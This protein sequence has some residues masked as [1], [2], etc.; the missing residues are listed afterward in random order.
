LKLLLD[1]HILLWLA[2]KRRMLPPLAV[3]LIEDS[4]NLLFFSVVSLWE[5]AIKRGLGRESMVDPRTL[6]RNLLANGYL[7]VVIEGEHALHVG[8]LPQIH[9]DPFD[10]MLISQAIT[11]N[12]TLV[13]S[14]AKITQYPGPIQRV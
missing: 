14:D 3:E 4:S 11:E 13:T 6:R 8:I 10:R 9:R 12:M 2:L 7:E 5:I 1:T